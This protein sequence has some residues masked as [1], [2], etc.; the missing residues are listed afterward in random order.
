[1]RE[2]KSKD[3]RQASV[4]IL[5][6]LGTY[7]YLLLLRLGDVSPVALGQTRSQQK[8]GAGPSAI[9]PQKMLDALRRHCLKANMAQ[10]MSTWV[11]VDTHLDP[12]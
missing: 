6:V 7:T 9:P 11:V 10:Q 1:M 4:D 8:R 3:A 12:K 2:K 5:R